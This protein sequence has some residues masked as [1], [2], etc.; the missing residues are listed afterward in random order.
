MAGR[1]EAAARGP[2]RV[3]LHQPVAF[4][5]AARSAA[6]DEV[7]IGANG[8]QRFLCGEE[9]H[10]SDDDDFVEIE[11]EGAQEAAEAFITYIDTRD[12]EWFSRPDD[13]HTI[14]VKRNGKVWK[15]GASFD[16]VKSWRVRS[17]RQTQSA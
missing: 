1:G 11:A 9:G 16:Y 4:A 2:A 8:M 5:R 10:C 6:Q 13:A 3:E 7:E 12:S 15:F 17:I 14:I